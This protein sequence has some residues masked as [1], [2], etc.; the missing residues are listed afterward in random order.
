MSL[1]QAQK[2]INGVPACLDHGLCLVGIGDHGGG[3][4]EQQ[5]AWCRDHA[6]AI[7]GWE[8]MFS[9]PSRFFEAVRPQK[10]LLPVVTGELQF[11]AVGCYTV[12]R[13]V[14]TG[15]RRAEHLLAQAE[16]AAL[17]ADAPA[18]TEAW[19]RVCFHHFHDTLGGTCIPGAYPVVLDQLGAAAAAADE[20]LQHNFRRRLNSLSD[21]PLQRIVLYNPSET[22]FDGFIE[23]EPWID[24]WQPWLPDC[25]LLDAAGDLVPF[26]TMQSEALVQFGVNGHFTRLL[27]QAHL[28]PDEIQALRIRRG[29]EAVSFAAGVSAPDGSRIENDRGIVITSD[30]PR[31]QVSQ[32]QGGN[33]WPRLR[34]QLIPDESDTWGHGIVGYAVAPASE[35]KWSPGEIMDSGP[36]MAAL[37]AR[38]T[39]GSSQ[40]H[41]EWRVYA[42]EDYAELKL[43]IDFHE[44][45]Q[46]LKLTFEPDNGYEES[47]IDGTLG[48][49]LRRPN[50]GAERPLRDWTLA[51]QTDGSALGIVA[52]DV[53]GI[54]GTPK[55]IR[56]TLLRSPLMAYHLPFDTSDAKRT[57]VADQGEH[58]FRFRFYF[59]TSV[60]PEI[61]DAAAK[62]M[63]RPPLTADLTRGMPAEFR[64]TTKRF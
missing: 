5:I 7:P 3:P 34:L 15:V 4:T 29:G 26:Q 50:H 24:W 35:V 48:G 59:G 54:D 20:I 21:D 38:G 10:N 2:C 8:I 1:E 62:N 57:V 12:Y 11:H 46:V 42:G 40:V 64:A 13:P 25:A 19:K 49:S 23:F 58:I 41:A 44:C 51:P 61:L 30:G 22:A 55:S 14:K 9:S 63:Q 16:R 18:I 47:R 39:V 33:N 28:A 32:E 6:H 27:V 43:K 60:T 45:R 52:P 53:F 31:S 37:A 56:L 17:P 36:L